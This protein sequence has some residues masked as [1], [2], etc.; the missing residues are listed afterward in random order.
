M[1]AGPTG[2]CAITGNSRYKFWAIIPDCFHK[3]CPESNLASFIGKILYNRSIILTMPPEQR[4]YDFICWTERAFFSKVW[5]LTVTPQRWMR[6]VRNC[7][8]STNQRR[9]PSLCI[10]R[11]SD[12]LSHLVWPTAFK[13]KNHAAVCWVSKISRLHQGINNDSS[14]TCSWFKYHLNGA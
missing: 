12:V 1:R 4:D 8:S 7:L 14:E 3:T 9:L 5:V 11:T 10:W 6:A 13:K 2:P